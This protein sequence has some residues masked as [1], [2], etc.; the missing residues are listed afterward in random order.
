MRVFAIGVAAALC[1]A[2]AS[3]AGGSAS[4]T[5]ATRPSPEVIAA[6]RKQGDDLLIAA[7][8]QDLFDNETGADGLA[9]IVLRHRPSGFI[10]QFEPGRAINSV[11]VYPNAHRGDD[12]GCNT[13]TSAGS[14]TTNFTLSMAAPERVLLAADRAIRLHVPGVQPAPS[15]VRT[16]R[17]ADSYPGLPTPQ[18]VRFVSDRT[19]EEDLIGQVDGWLVE[20]RFTAPRG[21]VES[22][23]LDEHWY[24][25]VAERLRR[26]PASSDRTPAA[27][28]AVLSNEAQIAIARSEGDRILA[29]GNAGPQFDNVTSSKV[30]ALRHRAS[31]VTCRFDLGQAVG[32]T[33]GRIATSTFRDDAVSCLGGDQTFRATLTIVSNR[34]QFDAAGALTAAVAATRSF[35]PRLKDF[36]GE[37]VTANTP[38]AM[39]E[40]RAAR[41]VEPPGPNQQYTYLGVAVVGDWILTEQ[42]L[43]PAAQSKAADRLGELSLVTAITD[44]AKSRSQAGTREG[45]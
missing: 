41:L 24:A 45:R 14:R 30:I 18:S 12:V 42:V 16:H 2:G 6:A 28:P 37:G 8:A 35:F 29:S 33:L 9:L 31:G 15:P 17:Y 34:D 5:S 36:A 19:L 44:A 25:T 22:D 1:L 27:R 38:A 32:V 43:G 20:D 39:P 26:G 11:V 40:H 21:F 10:C 23:A 13:M 4:A 3:R 7:Q